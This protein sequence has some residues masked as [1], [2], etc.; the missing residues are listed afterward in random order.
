MFL[1]G[2]V[3]VFRRLFK[4][5]KLLDAGDPRHAEIRPLLLVLSGAMRGVYGGGQVIALEHFGL[6]DVFDTVVG[7]S[8]GAPAGMYLLARQTEIGASI[9]WEECA[10]DRFISRNY[11]TVDADYLADVFRGIEGAKGADEKMIRASRSSF[12]IGL[13]SAQT[14]AGIFV[15]AKRVTPDIVQAAR[16]S[17]AI[18]YLTGKPVRLGADTYLD[19]AGAYPFPAREVIERF[20]PT[21][22]VV[23]TNS[24]PGQ[25][26]GLMRKAMAWL[27]T[28]G[29]PRPVRK[30]FT[31]RDR[32]FVH[33]LEYLRNQRNC[34]FALIWSSR[35]SSFE[36]RPE[37]LLAAKG[38]AELHLARILKEVSA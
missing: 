7:I 4:K 29:Y 31:S 14:G 1:E 38:E 21:D 26:D 3:E 17:I 34:R 19:G 6:S 11:L 35:L 15:D 33:S 8:A 32:R 2:D 20:R 22:L 12:F 5:Q 9:Y 25:R 28:F 37:V 24:A 23:F 18:P 36:K 30:A 13:T 10:T 27:A 16:A